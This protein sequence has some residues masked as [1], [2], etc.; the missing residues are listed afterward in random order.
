MKVVGGEGG[1]GERGGLLLV[2]LV[3]PRSDLNLLG[4]SLPHL[5]VKSWLSTVT[6]HVLWMLGA[7]CSKN[8]SGQ[9]R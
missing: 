5:V 8:G 3:L 4:K 7:T 2:D 6:P 9:R 1:R